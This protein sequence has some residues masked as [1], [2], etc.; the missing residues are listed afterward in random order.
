MGVLAVA[1]AYRSSRLSMHTPPP[2]L[3]DQR[4]IDHDHL[5]LLAIFHFIVAGLAL[6]G[7][8][9]LFLHWSF[10]RSF[11]DNPEIWRNQKG[12]PPPKEIFT[13]FKI[14][15]AIFGSITVLNGLANLISGLFLRRRIHRTFSLI[16]AGFNCLMVPLGTVLGAFTLVV[17]LR[18][19]VRDDYE[20]R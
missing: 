7:L 13:F 15:Y 8:G 19:S 4:K 12:G 6:A 1:L 18:D 11:F 9:F 17:L 5:K 2:L 14:F 3:R 16:V 10:M 20:N